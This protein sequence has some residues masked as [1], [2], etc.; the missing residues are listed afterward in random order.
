[1]H[2]STNADRCEKAV[3]AF[4][5]KIVKS[6]FVQI[7]VP[8]RINIEATLCQSSRTAQCGTAQ[9]LVFGFVYLSSS[10]LKL[11]VRKTSYWFFCP[12]LGTSKNAPVSLFRPKLSLEILD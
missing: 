3:K 1:M 10:S 4:P 8:K 12:I 2:V 6:V 11:W 7:A 9:N 5:L